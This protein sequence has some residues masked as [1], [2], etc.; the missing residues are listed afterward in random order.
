MDAADRKLPPGRAVAIY[1]GHLS[2]SA[3]EW[4]ANQG[5]KKYV[6]RHAATAD[7]DLELNPDIP[8]TSQ[9]PPTFLPGQEMT[10]LTTYTIRWRTYIALVGWRASRDAFVCARRHHADCGVQFFNNEVDSV[11]GDVAEDDQMISDSKSFVSEVQT[12]DLIGGCKDCLATAT[13][14]PDLNGAQEGLASTPLRELAPE[15]SVRNSP[16]GIACSKAR[17]IHIAAQQVVCQRSTPGTK[18]H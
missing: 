12:C 7:K 9:T 14:L 16:P 8:V 1:P 17:Q 11:D 2:V 18:Y 13:A 6:V 3:A 5:A 15:A 10:T 4:D